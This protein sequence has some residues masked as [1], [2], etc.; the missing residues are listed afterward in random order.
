MIYEESPELLSKSEYNQIHKTITDRI[1]STNEEKWNTFPRTFAEI[2]TLRVKFEREEDS[3]K[4]KTLEEIN[5]YI[6]ELE[7]KYTSV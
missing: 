1:L 6:E 5:S 4:M 3:D 7:K 2:D